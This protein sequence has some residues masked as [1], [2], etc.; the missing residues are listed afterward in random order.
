MKQAITMP[1]KL[2]INDTSTSHSTHSRKDKFSRNS[3]SQRFEFEHRSRLGVNNIDNSEVNIQKQIEK[4]RSYLQDI[5]YDNVLIQHRNSFQ[6]RWQQSEYD[7]VVT[8]Q[9]CI[10][11]FYLLK[12]IGKGAYGRVM[13]VQHRINQQPGAMKIMH[14]KMLTER[15]KAAAHLRNE[16]RVLDASH[17]PF[18]I[19]STFQFEDLSNIY[20][21]MEFASGG[22]LFTLVRDQGPFREWCASFYA[23]EVSC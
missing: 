13:L 6:R 20:I 5:Y 4:Q 23:A 21:V 1:E 8:N 12:T 3:E 9:I 19:R 11:D 7:A 16:K 10:R 22:D 15:K 14:K 17:F 18:L 2:G